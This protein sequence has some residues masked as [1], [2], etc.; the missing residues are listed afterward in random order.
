MLSSAS[1]RSLGD[2]PTRLESARWS[3]AFPWHQLCSHAGLQ[4][5]QGRQAVVVDDGSPVP[6]SLSL[7]PA[8]DSIM[9]TMVGSKKR[10]SKSRHQISTLVACRTGHM[11]VCYAMSQGWISATA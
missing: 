9:V 1:G 6:R 3:A 8:Q 2:S 10:W 4:Q 5:E 7:Q 11:Y